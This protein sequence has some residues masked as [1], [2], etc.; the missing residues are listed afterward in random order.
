MKL[1]TWLA[2][3][4]L[5][6][7]WGIPY[8]F[9][10]KALG[11]LSPVCVAWGRLVF[12]AIV[13]LPVAWKRGSLRDLRKYGRYI[14]AFAVLE[15]V[16]PFYLIALGESW[17]SSSL[18]GILLAAVPLMVVI[19][20]PVVGV[21]E[22]LGQRRL[23]GLIVGLVG[24]MALLGID[25]LHGSKEWI[26]AGCILL[27]TVGYATGPLIIQRHLREVDSLGVVAASVA[28]LGVVCTALGLLL[29]VYVISHAGAS[30]AA[31]VTYVNP[32]VAVLLGVLI[33]NEHF[34]VGAGVGLLLI[35]MGSWLAT[36][37]AKA[38]H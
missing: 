28:I 26:G 6:L 23:I 16:G 37:G 17:V 25:S 14:V 21:K 8:F 33:L 2:F 4:A 12:G 10:K 18:A 13:L 1:R 32:A 20:A 15:L 11:D 5:C 3:L 22:H 31:V 29:F 7:I 24:V 38:A 35:L 27:A 36:G 30:R 19:L 9:I 34:G